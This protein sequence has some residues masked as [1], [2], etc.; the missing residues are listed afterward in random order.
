MTSSNLFCLTQKSLVL[1][2]CFLSTIRTYDCELSVDIMFCPDYYETLRMRFDCFVF[3]E[4]EFFLSW[5][6]N[7]HTVTVW[8]HNYIVFH[9]RHTLE[10]PYNLIIDKI[11]N[12]I[13]ACLLTMSTVRNIAAGGE[14][15]AAS[16]IWYIKHEPNIT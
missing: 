2:S 9:I 13:C 5:I 14:R 4:A 10:L 8:L 15:R 6:L 12:H 16:N 1:K 3:E 7:F 11:N